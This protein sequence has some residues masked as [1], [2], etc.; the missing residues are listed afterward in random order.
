MMAKLTGKEPSEKI[1][2]D[3]DGN[4]IKH[5]NALSDKTSKQMV[6]IVKAHA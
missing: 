1:D 4:A 2:R 3:G 6:R 5:Q